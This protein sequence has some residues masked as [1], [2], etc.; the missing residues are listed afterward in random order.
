MNDTREST[1]AAA[2]QEPL[3][4]EP[5]PTPGP[6][7]RRGA[8]GSRVMAALLAA[9]LAASRLPAQDGVFVTGARVL[10][11]APTATSWYLTLEKDIIGPLGVDGSLLVLPG[12]PQLTG[13]C[14]ERRR[15]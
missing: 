13:T 6:H 5:A 12:S 11:G 8:G 2:G 7:M 3:L 9:A 10:A 15:T 1:D 14:T 4:T